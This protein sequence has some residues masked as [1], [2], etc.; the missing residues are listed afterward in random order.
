[1]AV[2]FTLLS[3]NIHKG[4]SAR[5]VRY[6]LHEL[7][8]AIIDIGADVV[9]L[10]EVVGDHS[11]HRE[12]IS[13]WPS[14]AQFEYLADTVWSHY[15]YGK[16]A[17]YDVGHHGNAILSKFPIVSFE[18]HDISVG[19]HECRGI[20]HAVLDMSDGKGTK[21]DC[22]CTHLGLFR[23]IRDKQFQLVSQLVGEAV[24]DGSS[25]IL[26]GD[27]ND[28]LLRACPVMEDK[29]GARELIKAL[30]GEVARTYPARFPVM[31]LDR[32]YGRGIEVR[33]AAALTGKPWMHLSDHVPLVVK[34]ALKDA[35]D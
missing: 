2:E 14:E 5:N 20:L 6:M 9:F 11:R 18:N 32:V 13:E 15:A 29:L 23:R 22:F 7:K 17:V 30:H 3:Y 25:L 33:A 21:L 10:Q 28:W 19:R 8:Q 26:A 24:A 4:F 27:F 12:R 35:G 34:V 31:C 1:M 16:N